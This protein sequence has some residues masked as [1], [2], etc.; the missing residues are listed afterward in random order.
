MVATCGRTGAGRREAQERETDAGMNVLI[1]GCGNVG[2]TLAETL[3]REGHN[4]TVIESDP[5]K[6]DMLKNRLD[7]AVV[8]GNCAAYS[9]LK[10]AGL[11]TCDVLIAATG[12]DEI[13]MLCCLVARRTVKCRTIARVRNPDYTNEIDFFRDGL[14]LSMVINPEASAAE[15]CYHL[16]QAPGAMDIDSFAQGRVQMATV[17]LPEGSPWAGQNL[18]AIQQTCQATF[19]VAVVERGREAFIPNGYSVLR[20]GDKLGIV[21]ESRDIDLVFR[22]MGV[23]QKR[24]HSVMIAGCG[25]VGFYLADQLLKGRFRVKVIDPS[26]QRCEELAGLLPGA[27]VICGNYHNELLLQEE[28]I[29]QMDAVAALSG[30]DSDNIVLALYANKVTNAKLITRINKITFGGVLSEIPIGA[31]VSPKALTAE[32][33][34]R[35][36]RAIGGEEEDSRMEAMYLLA[37]GRIEALSFVV[38]P[39]S[40]LIG[41]TLQELPLKKGVLLGTIIRN[42]EVIIPSGQDMLSGGDLVVVLTEHK[43]TRK[44]RDTLKAGAGR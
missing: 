42:G 19:L 25:K 15:T 31:V 26:R 12:K 36:A 30:V 39:D 27:E 11:D 1:A 13:N 7:A 37:D 29:G 8:T 23:R 14:G 16:L 38:L 33:I 18:I 24:I 6:A 34:L 21:M 3:N 43:G 40:Q 44:L 4:I 10:E 32:R 41:R 22:A 28:G 2:Y 35:Y 9:V 20:P 5:D 17:Q